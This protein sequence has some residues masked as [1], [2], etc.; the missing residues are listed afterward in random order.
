VT[1]VIRGRGG[2]GKG[3]GSQPTPREDPNTLRATSTARIIDVLGEGPIVG[4]VNGAR[5]IYFDGTPLVN[6]DGSPNF[7]GVTWALMAGLPDQHPLPGANAAETE[8]AVGVRVRADTP[9]VRT[10]NSTPLSAVRVKIRIPALSSVDQ[11][12]GSIYG[13]SVAIA[14]DV[15]TNTGQWTEVRQDT[16]AGKCT[17]PYEREYRIDLPSGGAPWQVRVRRLTPDNDTTTT[18]QNETWWSSYTEVLDWRLS[19]P[20]TAHIGL[21]IDAAYFSTIPRREYDVRGR[22]LRVPINYNPVTRTYTGVWNGTFKTAFTDNP[23]WVF[24]DLLTNERYGLGRHIQPAW[25]DKWALYEIAQYCDELVPDGAGGMEPR[26]TFNGALV[27]ASDAWDALQTVAASFRGMIYWGAGRITATQDRPGD[28]VKLVTNANVIDGVFSYQ[29]SSLSARHTVAQVTWSDPSN[30]FKPSIEWVDN[31]E[32]IQR[33]GVRQTE[34]AAVGCTSRGLARRLGRWLLDTEQT[35]TETVTYRAALDHA[36]LRPGD[37]I[38]VADRWIAGLRMGGRLAAATTTTLTLDAPVTLVPGET[39]AVRVTMPSGQ[40][41]ERQVTTGAGTH[42]TLTITPALP[43]APAANAV[44]LLAAGTVQPRQ[45]R[46][47]SVTEVEPAIFEVV[48]LFHDPNKYARVEL[49]LNVQSPSFTALPTGPLPRPT[50]LTAQEYIVVSGGSASAA[51]SISWKQPNDARLRSAQVE[52][53]LPGDPTWYPVGET[54]TSSIE[55]VGTREGLGRVRVRARDVFGRASAWTEQDVALLGLSAPPTDVED[56]RGTVLGNTLRL[57]WKPHPAQGFV[58]YRVRFSAA[59]TG[60][61]WSSSVDL[62]ERLA[63]PIAELPLMVGTYLVKA[64][65][66]SGALSP[67][68]AL[69]VNTATPIQPF[70]AVALLTQHPT[71]SGTKVNVSVANNK[72]SLNAGQ[73]VG[74]YS[75]ASPD[76]GDVYT[77]RV[78]AQ[79]AAAGLRSQDDVFAWGNVFDVEDIFGTTSD[80]WDVALEL[81]ATNDNPAGSPTW[82]PWQPFMVGDYS[83]RAFQF[84]MT[85]ESLDGGETRPIV[86]TLAVEIDM[87]DRVE[88]ADGINVPAAGMTVLFNVPFAATPAISVT[89]RN[90]QSGD[91]VEITNQSASGFDVRFRN[92]AGA[93]VARMMDWIASGYGRKLN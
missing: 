9:V 1:T 37:I 74:T 70:N 89:G 33:W 78:S 44:W 75:F 8:V 68:P 42:T 65:T 58:T 40:V 34:I 86:D 73:T 3:G 79:L 23:A 67:T 54:A 69:F 85:L 59:L 82:G 52:I 62:A 36:D 12:S 81:R 60:V 6:P 91:Y 63:A 50:N 22:T 31:P 11:S 13:T 38:A 17:S 30:G 28:P 20:D 26:Y 48:A 47:I 80:Q 27:A 56:V 87:P 24:Y 43:A 71:W 41:L 14:I 83:G 76:L 19:Y 29:G 10:I 46:V 92:A 77:S 2:G 61:L 21:A 7:K 55:Y 5:S 93:G 88:S 15:K 35:A 57:T 64:E 45:F 39:Y 25:V 18:L 32:G 66:P 53:R 72:L 51:L 4:L 90:L 16:I 49:G 84:R